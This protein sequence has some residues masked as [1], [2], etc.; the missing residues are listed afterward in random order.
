MSKL[1]SEDNEDAEVKFLRMELA[2]MEKLSE[3][4]LKL[5]KA[6]LLVIR[7]R[8]STASAVIPSVVPLPSSSN[9]TSGKKQ[10]VLSGKKQRVFKQEEEEEEEEEEEVLEENK[11]VKKAKVVRKQ[12]EENI[13]IP[14][15]IIYDIITYYYM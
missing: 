15:V 13:D 14:E 12:N 8:L 11:V 7:K 2:E 3:Q 9:K 1:S 6:E 4:R 5:A 10:R